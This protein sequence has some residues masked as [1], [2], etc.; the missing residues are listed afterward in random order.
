LPDTA[1]TPRPIRRAG[2]ALLALATAKVFIVDLASL[3]VA[4]PVLSLVAPGVLLLVS[5]VVY[6][7]RQ[8]RDARSGSRA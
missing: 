6:A 7:R 5:A 3:D 4:Y 2:L 8:Q 1:T